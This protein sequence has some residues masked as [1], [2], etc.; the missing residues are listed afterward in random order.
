MLKMG[1][2]KRGFKILCGLQ[3]GHTTLRKRIIMKKPIVRIRQP[4]VQ[5]AGYLTIWVFLIIS[6]ASDM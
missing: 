4:T 6:L 2:E 1:C 3:R 5:L